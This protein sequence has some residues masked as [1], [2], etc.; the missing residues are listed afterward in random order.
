MDGLLVDAFSPQ[1]DEF[2][3]L[4]LGVPSVYR[5]FLDPRRLQELAQWLDLGAWD[6]DRPGNWVAVWRE[7]LEG[8]A[9]G[10]EGR[11]LLKSPGHTFRVRALLNIFPAA[12]Y[13][14]IVRDP[15]EVF[16]SNR[17]MW[18]SMFQQYA[19]WTWEASHLDEFLLSALKSA[20]QCLIHATRHLAR[21]RLV[22]LDFRQ[23]TG[24]AVRTVEGLNRRMRL[25]RPEEM[26]NQ[27]TRITAKRFQHR[28]DSYLG[29]ELPSSSKEAVRTLRAA[30]GAALA[31]HG[32]P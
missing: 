28:S 24:D 18:A 26:R 22:V 15:E 5:G 27:L 13:I 9:D 20:T 31:S 23:L 30:Q 11:L 25:W 8:V 10:K 2:A 3:L 1:E 17:K 32:L 6:F 14:W 21:D 4:A 12:S 7:F 16:F 29:E 19:L